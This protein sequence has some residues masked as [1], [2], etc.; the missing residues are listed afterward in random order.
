MDKIAHSRIIP[1][2][3]IAAVLGLFFD[4]FAAVLIIYMVPPSFINVHENSQ[5]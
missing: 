1:S 3:L 2:G 5:K 4:F